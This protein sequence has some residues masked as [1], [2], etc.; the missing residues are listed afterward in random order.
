VTT[1]TEPGTSLQTLEALVAQAADRP[2]LEGCATLVSYTVAAKRP[3]DPVAI[4]AAGA[5]RS[6]YR[7]YWEQ[8]ATGELLIGLGEAD[9]TSLEGV[10]RFRDAAAIVREGGERAMI[11]RP[12]SLPGGLI[13]FAAFAFA[14]ERDPNGVWREIPSGRLIL[15][16]MVV[17]TCA[18]TT[19][20]TLNLCVQPNADVESIVFDAQADLERL[21]RLSGQSSTDEMAVRIR[22]RIEQPDRDAWQ[23]AVANSAAAIR[24]GEIEKVVLARSLQLNA[25]EP[26]SPE[27]AL[28]QLRAAGPAATVFAIANG[29]RCFIGAT[30]ERLVKLRDGVVSVDCLAGSIARGVDAA[31]DARLAQRLLDSAKDRAEHDVVVR[32]VENAL[33][34]VCEQIS[35]PKDAPEVRQ[36]RNVQHLSTPLTG[37]LREGNCVINLVER[38]HPTPAVGGFPLELALDVIREREGFDRGWYA[39]PI[40][41]VDDQGEGE[42]AVALRSAL[43]DGS[44]ATLFAGAGI[45]ADSDPAAEYAET[46][47]KM[48]PMLTA[49]GVEA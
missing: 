37:R 49:L 31:D 34:E 18:G 25:D 9:A 10:S 3:L 35:R 4:F 24:R 19:S 42:F 33:A 29:P 23:E 47:L 12:D 14:P 32:I 38:L 21:S 44:R 5:N 48:R 30:P 6:G 8:P 11:E 2:R 45:M 15:P 1:L 28:R 41:W 17:A 46:A 16:R 39:G 26:F 7:A 40:G 27:S 43:L 13:W 36:S 22:A 20:H